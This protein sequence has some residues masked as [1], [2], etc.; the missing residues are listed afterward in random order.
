MGRGSLDSLL[1][2]TIAGLLSVIIWLDASDEQRPIESA[3]IS[4]PGGFAVGYRNV[5][6]GYDAYAVGEPKVELAVRGIEDRGSPLAGAASEIEVWVDLAGIAPDSATHE[7]PVRWSCRACARR[8]LRVL[9]ASPSALDVRFDPVVTETRAVAIELE[10]TAAAALVA[11]ERA[12]DPPEVLV[13]GPQ[14]YVA[15]VRSVVARVDPGGAEGTELEAAVLLVGEDRQAT[16]VPRVTLVPPAA[17]V[18]LS[19]DRSGIRLPVAPEIVGDVPA[20]YFWSRLLYEPTEVTVS[21]DPPALQALLDAGRVTTVP[22]DLTGVTA[23]STFA[24]ELRLPS[25]VEALDVPT[26]GVTVTIQ[27]RRQ[28]GSRAVDVPVVAEGLAP[29][30][31][32]AP[33]PATVRVLVSGPQPVVEALDPADV[34]ARVDVSGLRAGRHRLEVA[35]VL[36]RELEALT[37]TPDTV[38]VALERSGGAASPTAPR[39]AP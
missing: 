17:V 24:A 28:P 35:V 27:V 5:A 15:R 4:P 33:S 20:G 13:S 8:G 30:L 23:D 18:R 25:G 6:P 3:A 9:G 29:T 39:A 16:P 2:I 34:V 32:F 37:I 7:L 12:A 31:T 19:L 22:I 26:S 1:S 10:E 14:R 36:P 11:D 21:G 38:E